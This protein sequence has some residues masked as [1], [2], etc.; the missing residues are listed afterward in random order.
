MA[1]NLTQTDPQV[2]LQ[3]PFTYD[4]T[5]G[6]IVIGFAAACVV[7]GILLTQAWTYF[8]RFNSDTGVYKMLVV[9]I[10]VLET[11]DQAFIGHFVYFYTVT[12][13][14]QPLALATGTTTWSVILQQ[15]IGSVVSTIVKCAFAT[16]VYRFS[17]K[18]IFITSF[19]ILLA[20]GQLGVAVAFTARAFELSSIP[21]V[22]SLK[23]LAT[24]SL[25]MGVLTDVLTAGALCFFLWRMRTGGKTAAN[26]L[27]TRLV[28]DAVNTGVL[29]TVVSL[30]TLLLFDFLEG[31]LIFAATYFLLSKLY[32]ISF[33]AT[34]NTR[35]V[36][37]GRGTDHEGGTSSRRPGTTPSLIYANSARGGGGKGRDSQVETNMFALGTR[38]P[39]VYVDDEEGAY[40][41]GAGAYE[42]DLKPG[43]PPEPARDYQ[44]HLPYP[45][46]V[47]SPYQL[48]YQPSNAYSYAV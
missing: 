39:S 22:F 30:S 26:S 44:P 35:R 23:L 43:F 7:Y 11:T 16:R 15:A 38:M 3:T 47:P 24:I 4:N 33:L 37:R 21:K 12:S 18:N 28:T 14:G 32:A 19:L 25:A 13:A 45:Q 40:D 48:P 17:D 29:T 2:Q 1:S 46:Q 5:L 10:L 6:A 20:L 9:L 8:S 41:A 36:V 42:R 31:N 27:I 34:L